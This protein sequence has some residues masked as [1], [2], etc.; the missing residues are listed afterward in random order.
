MEK[1]IW[2]SVLFALIVFLPQNIK[3]SCSDAEIVRLQKLAN[4]VNIN[5]TYDE[6]SQ[7]FNIV[8]T[9]LKNDLVLKDIYTGKTYVTNEEVIIKNEN[10][11]RY[12]FM[13]YA[14]TNCSK[15]YII[16]K[17]IEM[18]YY[19]IYFNSAQ[20][21]GIENFYYCSKWMNSTIDVSDFIEK[22]S[23][24]KEKINNLKEENSEKN[25]SFLNKIF[26]KI[27]D[28]YVK[29][30]SLILPIV[31]VILCLIIYI[32]NKKNNIV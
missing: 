28:T 14:N 5:Y 8:I 21:K 23:T 30:Y 19:N 4:N 15:E 12:T 3:A 25:T 24:Y 1:K 9:N 22:T 20:C 13:I 32:K 29:N 31:I 2:F 7:K 18:P 6:K 17:Y 11:G 10:S 16:T 27:K 26:N